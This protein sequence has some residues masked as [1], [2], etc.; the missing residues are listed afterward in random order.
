MLLQ[1]IISLRN[2]QDFAAITVTS[3]NGF[4]IQNVMI[5]KRMVMYIARSGHTDLELHRNHSVIFSLSLSISRSLLLSL[6]L[7]LYFSFDNIATPPWVG[8]RWLQKPSLFVLSEAL[9]AA[10]GLC[11]KSW[12]GLMP[13]TNDSRRALSVLLGSR[14]DSSGVPD[15]KGPGD[16]GVWGRIWFSIRRRL[17]VS[18]MREQTEPES[19][20]CEARQPAREND[21]GLR[22]RKT[23]RSG[24]RPCREFQEKSPENWKSGGK[25]NFGAMF[26]YFLSAAYFQTYLLSYFGQ[27]ARNLCSSTSSGMQFLHPKYV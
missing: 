6:S 20:C 22:S 21:S 27:K 10:H 24:N 3:F 18:E 2:F 23:N 13:S 5:L 7:S 1:K 8:K 14:P 15:R 12:K 16:P 26:S 11:L 9:T 25:S 19:I 4:E 17:G